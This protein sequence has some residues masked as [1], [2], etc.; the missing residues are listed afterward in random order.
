[1]RRGWTEDAALIDAFAADAFF[2]GL[3][4]ADVTFLD[5]SDFRSRAEPDADD[6][7]DF[8]E[9]DPAPRAEVRSGRRSVFDGY[10]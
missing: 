2:A 10:D 9:N 7:L 1:M 3:R 5:D 6:W 4:A 8:L